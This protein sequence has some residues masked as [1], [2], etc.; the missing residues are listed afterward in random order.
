MKTYSATVFQRGLIL[1]LGAVCGLTTTPGEA[2]A[3]VIYES[4]VLGPTGIAQ[5]SGPATNISAAVFTGVRFELTRPVATSQVGGHFV[6]SSGGTFFGAV[7][8]LD[9]ANDFPNSGN[10][11]SPDVLGATALTFPTASAEVHGNLSLALDP[12]W[13][14]LVFGSGLFGATGSGV[15]LRNGTDIGA[16]SYIAYQPMSGV[17]WVDITP[18]FNDHR[19]LVLGTVVPEPTA[20][21]LG[22]VPVLFVAARKCRTH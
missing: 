4:A 18:V 15:A 11:S 6:S 13:Y 20:I 7:V 17:S 2:I 12:G 10:L 16:P 21:L 14:A 9:D 22:V 3:A 1:A 5:G 8:S 19:F